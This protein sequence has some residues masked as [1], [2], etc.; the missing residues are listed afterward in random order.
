[1]K[2]STDVVKRSTLNTLHKQSRDWLHVADHCAAVHRV[3]HAELGSIP[4][5]GGTDPGLL[6]IFDISARCEVTD[7]EIARRVARELGSDP[8][9]WIE[10]I[11]DRP[12]HDR[13]Y[14]IEPTKLETELGW[15][16]EYEF[17]A[18]IAET[19][20]WYVEHRGWWEKVIADKGDLAVDW[21]QI[22][23]TPTH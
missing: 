5:E 21:C 3:L 18:G 1:M 4:V 15:E 11:P 9:E 20:A 12:N 16:P 7:L 10:H 8:G 2:G 14:V 6:P 17:E 19:V 13:R 23:P 22:G